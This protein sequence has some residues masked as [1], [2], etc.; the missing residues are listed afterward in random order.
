M[1]STPSVLPLTAHPSLAQRFRDV[2]RRTEELCSPLLIEDYVVQS[3]PDVSPPKWH[4]AHTTWFFEK[5]VLLK[6]LPGYKAYH[7]GFDFLFNSYYES[8]GPRVERHRRGLLSRPSVDEVL[9]YRHWVESRVLEL[10]ERVHVTEEL[11]EAIVLGLQHEQQHQ[12][13][14]LTDIKHI[15][16]TNPLRPAYLKGIERP[17]GRGAIESRWLEVEGG[18]REIGFE[19]EGF[20]FDNEKPRHAALLAPFRIASRP[21]TQGELAEFVE[22]GGY[23]DPAHWLSDGW[24]AAR[25]GEWDAPLYWER[26]GRRWWVMTLGGM[27]ELREDEPATHLSFYEA[28]A[29]ARWKGKRLPTEEEWETALSVLPSRLGTFAEAKLFHPQPAPAGRPDA[30]LQMLG[31]VWE[32]TASAYRPYPGFVPFRGAFAEYNGKFMCN[33]VVLRGGSC[34]TPQEHIRPTYRNFFGPGARWQFSGFRLAS[35]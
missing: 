27:R 4:L 3:M 30:L 9:R 11:L 29:F 8:V 17:G 7:P 19:G 22:A 12:E 21:V 10:L 25:Q 14:L 24:A 28:D 13:L 1:S 33:Q 2:R 5:F 18:A 15:F 35:G 34:A 16:W 23:S 6:W 32:W 20:A 26:Q 31:D